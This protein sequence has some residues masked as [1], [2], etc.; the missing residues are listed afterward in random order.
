MQR[1]IRKVL[2]SSFVLSIVLH[3]LFILSFVVVVTYQPEMTEKEPE[4]ELYIPSYTFSETANQTL[5]LPTKSDVTHKEKEIPDDKEGIETAAASSSLNDYVA[6]QYKMIRS[7]IKTDPVHLIGEKLF[8]DPL[9]KLIGIALTK[10]LVYPKIARQL[11]MR[12]I[13]SIELLLY[14][15]GTVANV[16]LVNSSRQRVLDAIALDAVQAMSPV[17]DV[18]LYIKSPKPLVINVIF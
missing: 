5:T 14:P 10:H 4:P 16:R 17:R 11:H 13:V 1:Q 9:R 8:D 12:G 15:D 6:N 3:L 7:S 18:D 2:F